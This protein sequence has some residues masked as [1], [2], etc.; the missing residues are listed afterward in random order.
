MGG[1]GSDTT[2]KAIAMSAKTLP[3]GITESTEPDGHRIWRLRE[4]MVLHAARMSAG[5]NAWELTVVGLNYQVASI[6]V[7]DEHLDNFALLFCNLIVEAMA[8]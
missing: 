6:L 1:G 7:L 8:A 2:R 5:L 3:A 4:N